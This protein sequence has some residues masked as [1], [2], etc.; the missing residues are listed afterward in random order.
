MIKNIG[1][2]GILVQNIKKSLD[3]LA[4]FIEF[5]RPTIKVNNEE[6]IKF[7]FVDLFNIGVELIQD[8]SEKG[9]LRK[10]LS[11]KGDLLDHF[12]LVSDN[13]EEDVQSLEKR[14]IEMDHERIKIG[15]R[16][17]KIAMTT[18]DAFNGIHIEIS[19]P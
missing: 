9:E 7:T 15:L 1:H 17:K 16:N 4:Q 3:K 18:A 14:G 10:M 11:E 5:D 8:V 2:I 13:I 19:E 6:G 12:C